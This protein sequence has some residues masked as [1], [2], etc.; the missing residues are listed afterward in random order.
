MDLSFDIETI[1]NSSM[2]ERMPEPEVKT[3]NLK[4]P[5]KIAEKIAEAKAEQQSRMAL[6]PLYG[7]VCAWVGAEDENAMYFNCIREESDA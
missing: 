3:G 5:A 7:R 2:I 1:A 4:D 6:S